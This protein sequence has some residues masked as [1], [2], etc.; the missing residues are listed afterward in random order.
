MKVDDKIK[1]IDGHTIAEL[2]PVSAESFLSSGQI[3][4]GEVVQLGIDRGGQQV[5]ATVTSIKW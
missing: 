5:A 2:T 3:G 4:V 1:T